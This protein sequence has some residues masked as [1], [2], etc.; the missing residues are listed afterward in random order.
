MYWSYTILILCLFMIFRWWQLK[1]SIKGREYDYRY[2]ED[3]PY[4]ERKSEPNWWERIKNWWQG[5]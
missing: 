5:R 2:Y 1:K 3:G 4:G